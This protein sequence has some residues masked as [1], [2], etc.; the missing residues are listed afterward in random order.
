MSCNYCSKTLGSLTIPHS[1]LECRY[2]QSMYCPVCMSYGHSPADCPNKIAWAV[3]QGKSAQGLKNLEIRV[4]DT[5]ESIRELLKKHGIKSA[6][7]KLENRKILRNLA[8][9]LKP[10]R[11]VIF[12]SVENLI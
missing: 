10:P 5:E 12:T 1:I 9:S 4:E 3:R 2:R 6:S 8:N 7:R 11:L